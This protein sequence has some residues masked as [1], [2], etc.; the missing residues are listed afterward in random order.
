ME[1]RDVATKLKVYG[2]F[3]LL[4]AAICVCAWFALVE[5]DSAL[6]TRDET[7]TIDSNRHVAVIILKPVITS[8][9]LPTPDSDLEGA[10]DHIAEAVVY[11]NQGRREAA[12]RALDLAQAVALRALTR[13]AAAEKVSEKLNLILREM[14]RARLNIA[15]GRF[16]AASLT[17]SQLDQQLDAAAF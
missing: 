7:V 10:G 14:E 3:S 2:A 17:L 8:V 11:S 15:R 6:R 4:I 16:D 12:L 1:T 5:A 9:P 13:R